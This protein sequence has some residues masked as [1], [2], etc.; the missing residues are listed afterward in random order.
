MVKLLLLRILIVNEDSID[1]LT[2]DELT[3]RLD[4][5]MIG[6]AAEIPKTQYFADKMEGFFSEL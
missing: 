3:S 2:R 5:L 6:E 4:D 1:I